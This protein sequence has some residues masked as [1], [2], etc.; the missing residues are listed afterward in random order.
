MFNKL[1]MFGKT[2]KRLSSIFILQILIVGFGFSTNIVITRLFGKESLGIWS[3]FFSL[4]ILLGIVA[5]FGINNGLPKLIA[6]NN[7]IAKSAVKKSLIII[8]FTSVG[9]TLI[10]ISL[11]NILN[12]NPNINYFSIYVFL[13]VLLLSYY[14]IFMQT[15]IGF[16]LHSQGVL[17]SLFHRILF[18][19]SIFVFFL[20]GNFNLI[21][22]F[23]SLAFLPFFYPMINK[24]KKL[25]PE[26]S[27]SI[28]N[29][30]FYRT[31][32]SFFLV[33][34]SFFSLYHIDRLSIIYI[35]SYEQL[36]TFTAWASTINIIRL[37]AA[38]L[39]IVLVP[40]AAIFQYKIK[41]SFGKLLIFLIPFAMIIGG[42]SFLVVP[43]FYGAGFNLDTPW[44]PWILVISSSLLVI[45]TFFN[46]I[47][48]GENKIKKR[49]MKILG[50]D[51]ALSIFLNIFLNII[52]IKTY[53]VIGAPIATSI[54]LLLK[55]ILMFYGLK[56]MRK[57][58]ILEN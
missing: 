27:I 47:Y 58:K 2:V 46:S 42:L 34:L 41:K 51:A 26:E 1:N 28:N 40:S 10:G 16:K 50:I 53:G 29:K 3:Y 37:V 45:Y 39:P 49:D 38:S 18:F 4:V 11:T 44:L 14:S 56:L 21:L 43:L 9:V 57:K 33:S 6:I 23:S 30:I 7:K 20:F 15:I 25:I 12:L 17:F 19:L 54:V 13:Y 8:T 22:L 5:Q 24:I 52:F 35:L 55:I 48:V 31:S 32:F 36:G